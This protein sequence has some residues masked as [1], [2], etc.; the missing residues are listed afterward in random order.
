[1]EY[2]NQKTIEGCKCINCR[3]ARMEQNM[4]TLH[5][6]MEELISALNGSPITRSN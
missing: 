3:M 2:F 5:L 1:M 6:Q 4:Q